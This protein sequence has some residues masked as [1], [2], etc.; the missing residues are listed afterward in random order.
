MTNVDILARC[1]LQPGDEGDDGADTLH[2]F[3]V[4]GFELHAE[5]FF[6]GENEIE[7]LH[8]IPVLN[9]LGRGLGRDL[10][11][12]NSEDIAGYGPDLGK[13]VGCQ[14]FPPMEVS[15]GTFSLIHS[16]QCRVDVFRS[17]VQRKPAAS[18]S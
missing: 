2:L 9:G 6:D 7:M 10:V 17:S 11:G 15:V 12:W 3:D 1:R 13:R 14:F 5:F 4:F 16:G 18:D 8:G